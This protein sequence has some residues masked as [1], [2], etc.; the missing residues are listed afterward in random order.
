M[1]ALLFLSFLFS[2][3]HHVT[4]PPN[5][6]KH[7][8]VFTIGGL[9]SEGPVELWFR[10]DADTRELLSYEGPYD[11]ANELKRAKHH[12]LAVTDANALWA[13]ARDVL[14]AGT[15]ATENASDYSQHIVINDDGD[16]IDASGGGP[17][18]GADGKL[19][20]TMLEKFS[21]QP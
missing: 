4:V 3:C 13:C 1:K 10:F 16:A 9:G 21:R 19:L 5:T 14:H 15:P 7:G 2:S 11:G 8:L 20:Q 17:F 12:T 6:P 18:A